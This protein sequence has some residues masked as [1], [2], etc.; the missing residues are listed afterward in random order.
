MK[1]RSAIRAAFTLIELLVAIAIIAVLIGLLLPAV[2]K[3]RAASARIKCS[4][5]LKQIGLALH[6][7]HDAN[8]YFPRGYD[9]GYRSPSGR[10]A[11]SQWMRHVLPYLEQSKDMQDDQ[12]L[13]TAVCPADP[14]GGATSPGEGFNS[15]FGLSWYV[16]LDMAGYLDDAGTIVSNKFRDAPFYRP[17][18]V[19]VDDIADGTSNT[20]AIGERPPN[21]PGTNPDMYWGWWDWPSAADTRTPVRATNTGV[22][23]KVWDTRSGTNGQPQTVSSMMFYTTDAA[24]AACPQPSFQAAS[25]A[26]QCTFNSVSSFHPGG[27]NFLFDDGSVRFLTYTINSVLSGSNPLVTVIEALVTRKGGETTPGEF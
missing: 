16:A 17:R 27:A 19:T 6:S 2:Q 4:N 20:T 5:N 7:Y 11:I 12:N 18:K 23:V 1:R 15:S 14:R 3:V 9:P 22:F 25:L 8:G 21:P 24:G 13:P 10:P 26:N